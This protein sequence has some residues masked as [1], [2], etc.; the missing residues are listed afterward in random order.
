MAECADS[1]FV[2]QEALQSNTAVRA[3]Q[4]TEVAADSPFAEYKVVRGS[5]TEPVVVHKVVQIPVTTSSPSF[6]THRRYAGVLCVRFV[7][8]DQDNDSFK[9]Y[10]IPGRPHIVVQE[11][12]LTSQQSSGSE[13]NYGDSLSALTAGT[14]RLYVSANNLSGSPL[15]SQYR[16]EIS[17]KSDHGGYVDQYDTSGN[18]SHRPGL[19]LSWTN[20]QP[21]KTVELSRTVLTGNH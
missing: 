10:R 13:K 12:A 6:E 15:G 18:D 7:H 21:T 16:K 20:S 1:N 4:S 19:I 5:E 17:L 3:G 2:W 14:T 8:N 9:T 11:S